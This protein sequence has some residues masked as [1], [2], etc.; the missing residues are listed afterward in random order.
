MV[1]RYGILWKIC[2]ARIF[3]CTAYCT[4]IPHQNFIKNVKYCSKYRT[5]NVVEIPYCCFN[6]DLKSNFLSFLDVHNLSFSIV[7]WFYLIRLHR[8]RATYRGMYEKLFFYYFLVNVSSDNAQ[9]WMCR[10]I[11]RIVSPIMAYP[12]KSILLLRYDFEIWTFYRTVLPHTAYRNKIPHHH[13]W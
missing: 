12:S 2:T 11:R 9:K 4:K 13:C 1:V 3:F 5:L 10:I 8:A 6:F 7:S